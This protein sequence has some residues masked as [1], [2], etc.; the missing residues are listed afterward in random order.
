[1][2]IPTPFPSVYP[3]VTHSIEQPHSYPH[4]RTAI[5]DGAA[6]LAVHPDSP[7]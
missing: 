3:L 4:P 7:N 6:R 2:V 1:M 5:A